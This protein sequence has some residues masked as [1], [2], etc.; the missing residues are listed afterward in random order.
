MTTL[1]MKIIKEG[2]IRYN[3][4]LCKFEERACWVTLISIAA[5]RH[6]ETH[7]VTHILY[8]DAA[9]GDPQ[10]CACLQNLNKI[11]QSTAELLRYIQF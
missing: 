11:G 6:I 9:S 2:P 8:H 5:K 1:T 3:T 4:V 7:A 10:A